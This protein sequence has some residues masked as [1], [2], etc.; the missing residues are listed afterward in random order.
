M[1]A[2]PRVVQALVRVDGDRFFVECVEYPIGREAA[3][4]DEAM[5]GI[6]AAIREYFD[7]RGVEEGFLLVFSLY[8]G[9]F[10]TPTG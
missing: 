8:F 2:A 7:A 9:R 4:L 5:T 3:S 10:G 6:E 1:Q